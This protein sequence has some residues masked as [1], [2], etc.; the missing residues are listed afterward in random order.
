[1][2]IDTH[3]HLD[4]EAFDIDRE[5]L[6]EEIF[7]K[8]NNI[9]KVVNISSSFKSCYSSIE[10]IKK[11]QGIYAAIGIH[12]CDISEL[13]EEKFR[14][15]EKLATNDK[16]VAIGE[17]GLDYYWEK[18][19]N[20]QQKYWF[21]RQIDL[22]KKLDL[23]IVI[24]SRDAAKDTFDI[25]EKNIDK[26]KNAVLHCYS[27]SLE[28]AK[29][30]E[31]LNVFFGIGGVA[32][33]KNS[34]KIKEVIEYLPLEKI[35]LETDAP[36]LAPAPFRGKRNSSLYLKYIIE[37]ISNIKKISKEEVIETTN[38]NSYIL[39]NKMRKENDRK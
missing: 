24:H 1:M 10:L 9:E 29:E 27:Y 19:N 38:K 7:N 5:K 26:I 36:Y 16:V 34:K 15:I 11:Y 31:K 12:P 30:F 35:V 17:I 14:E 6:I 28:M 21:E 20:K 23:P 22:S 2:I 39:Y 3:I 18:E 37:E 32:T 4:D 13:N 8:E 33:F 25:L